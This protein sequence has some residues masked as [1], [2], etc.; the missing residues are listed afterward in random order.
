[1]KTIKVLAFSGSFRSGSY[2][3]KLLKIAAGYAKASGADVEVM[4]LKE[5]SMPVYDGD[6][7]AKGLPASVLEFKAKIEA[8]DLLIIASPEYNY[9]VPGGLKNAIDWA[10]RG[11]NSFKGKHAVVCGA[12]NGH[13][14]TARMQPH[15][16]QVLECV[17]VFVLPQPQV[18]IP[19]CE[20]A[21]NPDDSLKDAKAAGALKNLIELTIKKAAA[22]ES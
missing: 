22:V 14:G 13:Y 7:Q 1:M 21:F 16:R 12:S 3:R 6:I 19:Y 10:S 20:A 8:S 5:L 11:E 18:F 4:D 9:S 15:L 17:N 2:N